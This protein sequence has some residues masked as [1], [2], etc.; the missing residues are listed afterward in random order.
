MGYL[1]G[2]NIAAFALMGID[3]RRAIRHQW[4]IKEITLFLCAIIGGG[5]GA[6]IGM[7]VFH[8][9]TKHWYFVLGMPLLIIINLVCITFV[10]KMILSIN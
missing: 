9:K 1:F 10:F 2:I 4:R 6:D 7:Y 8:H 3:K 5:I